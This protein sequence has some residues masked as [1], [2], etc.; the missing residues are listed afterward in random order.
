MGRRRTERDELLFCKEF[1]WKRR[2]RKVRDS[3]TPSPA[4]VD[5]RATQKVAHSLGLVAR[6]FLGA[7]AGVGAHDELGVTRFGLRLTPQKG[8]ENRAKE[9]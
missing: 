6:R 3:G 4:H 2:V 7:E 5:V 9:A 1:T 8:A